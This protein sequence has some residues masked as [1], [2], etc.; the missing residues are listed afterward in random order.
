MNRKYPDQTA[1]M[2]E[3]IWVSAILIW[4]NAPFLAFSMGKIHVLTVK[5][6]NKIVV[7]DSHEMSSIIFSEKKIDFFFSK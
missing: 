2:R 7:D 5:T 3:L 1:R 6:P 4:Y